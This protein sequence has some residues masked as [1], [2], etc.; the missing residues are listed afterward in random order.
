MT[1]NQGVPRSSRGWLTKT[2]VTIRLQMFFLFRRW[3][4]KSR[5]IL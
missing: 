2:S 5:G 3:S 4:K 1:F